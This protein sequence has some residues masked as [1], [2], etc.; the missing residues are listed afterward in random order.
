[1]T[2]VNKTIIYVH[3]F[4]WWS[5]TTSEECKLKAFEKIVENF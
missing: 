2:V 5:L 4:Y 3:C 1:M